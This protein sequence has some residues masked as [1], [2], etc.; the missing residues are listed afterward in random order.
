MSILSRSLGSVVVLAGLLAG[1]ASSDPIDAD[2]PGSDGTNPATDALV[3]IQHN[4][5]EDAHC[6][7]CSEGRTTCLVAENRCVACD[8]DTGSG[9]P[10]GQEC[11]SWGNCVPLGLECPTDSHGTPQLTCATNADCAACDPMHLVCDG[12]SG[13]CVACTTED[14]SACM[15]TATCVNNS[16]AAECPGTCA[17]DT[18]CAGCDGAGF[19]AHACNA[20][21]CAECSPTHAC[22]SGEI[23]SANGT[24]EAKCGSDA[25]GTCTTDSDCTGCAGDNHEC[26]APINGGTG[27]CGPSAAGCSD[28]GASVAVLPA[29]FDQVT[30][31]CSND[32]DCSGVGIQFN[33]G[34]ELRDLTGF[35]FIEDANID[36]AMS[37]CASVG[38]GNTSCGVCVP[39][40]DD[41]DC[42]P[43]DIDSI[44]G[45]LFGP[46]GG[47]V[48]AFLLDQMF[49]QNEHQVNMYCQ[50][51]AGGYGVCAPCPGLIYECGTSGGGTNPGSGTC[52][53]DTCTAGG[54]LDASCGSCEADMCAYDAYCCST[55]WDDL[56]ISEAESVC[57][58]DCGGGTTPTGPTCHD[59]CVA[60]D[61]L[62]PTCNACV[63]AICEYD[64]YCCDTEWDATCV[65]HVDDTCSPPC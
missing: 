5:T 6:G 10:E 3:C 60:G 49:G 42:A 59:E 4:C 48:A 57:G 41:G 54:A 29:P 62:D 51:V 7:G 8:S 58:I 43:I 20:H 19:E 27:E 11:S 13:H 46:V 56:C 30:N 64:P 23:C 16:C 47:I 24:C 52:D 37:S 14:T 65:S 61:M 63:Q 22:P 21:Q 45:D 44:S 39:C 15:S 34:K 9:C 55:T 53:H 28:L 1:C 12:A 40:Q 26:H 35:D 36:Y 2:G 38:I 31:L 32:G 18:D 33:I 50:A 17:T 25:K